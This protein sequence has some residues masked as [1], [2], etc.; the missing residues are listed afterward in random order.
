MFS[1]TS[2]FF[3]AVSIAWKFPPSVAKEMLFSI[4]SLKRKL[5]CGTYA[6]YFLTVFI[7]RELMSCPSRNIVQSGTL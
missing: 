7:G 6:A 5:S 4:V 2:A 3:A 1:W